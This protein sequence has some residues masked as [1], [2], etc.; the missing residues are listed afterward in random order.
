MNVGSVLWDW[1]TSKPGAQERIND[2]EEKVKDITDT[3][4]IF[5]EFD[6][7]AG[8]LDDV[9]RKY[10]ALSPARDWLNGRVITTILSCR[11]YRVIVI[12]R[13]QFADSAAP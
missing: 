8:V 4:E 6:E 10:N 9:D 2:F 5:R 11:V 3:G 13:Q 12:V 1:G 7:I